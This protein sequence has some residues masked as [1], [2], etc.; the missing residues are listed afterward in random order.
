MLAPGL[1]LS[2]A[3]PALAGLPWMLAAQSR[4]APG[5]WPLAIAYG[6]VLGLLITI[7]G[8]RALHLAHLP[9]NLF[10]AAI[11]PACAGAS[12][13][14]R[15]R[16]AVEFARADARQAGATWRAMNRMTRIVCV[17]ALGLI[18]LRL[19]TL[20][21]ELLLRPVFPWEA[22]SAVAAKARVWYELGVL[23]PFVPPASWL[24]GLD[25]FT[26]TEPGAFALP[27]LLL[28][29]TA[30]AIGQWHEGA[31]GFPWWM[32]GASLVLALYGH[33][34][35]AGGGVAFSLSVAYLFL[36]LPLVDLHIALTG[37][38]QWI[39]A[40]GVGLA[41]CALLRWLEAPSRE[42]LYCFA[43]GAALAILSMAST[44]PWFAIF[45]V[46]IAIRRW[47]RFAGKLAVG[48]PLLTLL[49]LLA[50]L[51]TPLTI[52]GMVLQLQV[53]RGWGE[54]L[55]SLFLLDNW[56]LLYGVALLVA[57]IGWHYVMSP[58][59][60]AR[61]WIIGMGLGLLFVWGA[62][63]LP[64]FWYGGLR[65]FSYAALQFAPL[66]MLWTAMAARAAACRDQPQAAA[67]TPE[68]PA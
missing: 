55:E 27:S 11:L 46:A 8:M 52:T 50:L 60:L 17:A 64:G 20:G 61:T 34:R 43:I 59:W 18:A 49:A 7:A 1:L 5:G 68:V 53:A 35:R 14:W 24:E 44:W 19:V 62:L 56:H 16:A 40:T 38:P 58:L 30:H 10:T 4:R 36:S 2:V 12:G 9:I 51:Q 13:W 26:D 6:Y 33:L 48:I 45:A 57:I 39:A 32:L 29:W 37:A 66:L 63:S 42:L 3:L 23:A 67:T 54:T 21:A 41:G 47:P 28:V 22:V 15:M 25:N 65:D 31:I